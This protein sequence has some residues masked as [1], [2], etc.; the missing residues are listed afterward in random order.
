[1]FVL[2][3]SHPSAW[4]RGEGALGWIGVWGWIAALVSGMFGRIAV[5][6]PKLETLEGAGIALHRLGSAVSVAAAARRVKLFA[7]HTERATWHAS[8]TYASTQ[9]Q[10]PVLTFART[11]KSTRRV[12]GRHAGAGEFIDTLKRCRRRAESL[13]RSD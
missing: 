5:V 10:P 8:W 6:L 2:L 11:A 4:S 13:D 9:N 12:M 1:M 3:R 7:G